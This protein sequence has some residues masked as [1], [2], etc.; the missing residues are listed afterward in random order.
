MGFDGKVPE[1]LNIEFKI[2]DENGEMVAIE[3]RFKRSAYHV[4][5]N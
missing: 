3:G 4:S 1:L 5:F 2:H